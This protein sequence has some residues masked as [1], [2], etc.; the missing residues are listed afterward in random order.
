MGFLDRIKELANLK[1][2]IEQ[3]N[4]ELLDI[5]NDVLMLEKNRNDINEQ[6][7]E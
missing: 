7:S 3:K 6:I 2:E 1:N 5:K 4:V